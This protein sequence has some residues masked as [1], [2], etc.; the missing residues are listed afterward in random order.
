MR[1]LYLWA[2][3]FAPLSLFCQSET[4]SSAG[5]PPGIPAGTSP[6]TSITTPSLTTPAGGSVSTGTITDLPSRFLDKLGSKARSLDEQISRQTQKYLDHLTK[7]E[8]RLQQKLGAID[9]KSNVLFAYSGGQYAAL[10]AKMR[11]ETG[12]ATT[13]LQGPYLPHADSVR[14][15]L[16]FLQQHPESLSPAQAAALQNQ[17]PAVSGQWQQLQSKFADA[18][19]VRQ[20]LSERKQVLQQYLSRMSN[21]PSAITKEYQN[22][23]QSVYYYSSQLQQYRTLLDHPDQLQQK[24]MAALNRAPGFANFVQKNNQLAMLFGG[25]ET[26]T[27]KAIA[28]LQTRDAVQ[29]LIKAKTGKSG[30]PAQD[31]AAGSTLQGGAQGVGGIGAPTAGGIASQLNAAGLGLSAL[32]DRVAKL[33]DAGK[34]MD[35]PNFKPNGQKTKSFWGRLEYGLNLQTQPSSSWYPTTTNLGITLGYR[36]SDNNTVGIGASAL[37]GWGTDIGHVRVTGSGL[38]LRSY[39]DIHLKKTFFL[40]GGLEY[41]YQPVFSNLRQLPGIHNWQQSGLIGVSKIV[42]VKSRVFS[43]TKLQLLWDVLSYSQTPQTAPIKFRVGYSF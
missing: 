3:L 23:N 4:N 13:V 11:G 9:P 7:V 28:G 35:D 40:S 43:K 18:G 22:Y 27:A 2:L 38:G 29:E 39:A 42:S 36:L 16:G 41:N 14:V 34:D 15:S 20:Y 24:A 17:L 10:V 5:T 33:G 21:L 1:K 31:G 30:V 12:S 26:G 8:Q 19:Q 25:V 6:G 32:Q 37:I